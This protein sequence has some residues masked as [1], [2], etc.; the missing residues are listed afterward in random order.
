MFTDESIA[1]TVLKIGNNVPAGGFTSICTLEPAVT[2]LTRN[3][4]STSSW[5]PSDVTAMSPLIVVNVLVVSLV[6]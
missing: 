1:G 3:L 4:I 6:P 5:G 2:V